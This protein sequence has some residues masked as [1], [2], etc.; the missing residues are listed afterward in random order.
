MSDLKKNFGYNLLLTTGNYLI[1]LI[2]YPYISRVLGV[3]K[4]GICGFVDGLINYFV[5]FAA[6]GVFGLG[7]REIARCRDN[8]IQRSIVF[9]S[10]FAINAVCTFFSV[11]VLVLCTF[12]VE[13]FIPYKDFLLIGILKLIFSL[14]LIEW[15]F[16]GLQNFRYIT[17]RTLVIRLLYLISVFL[18]VKRESDILV[19]YF[20]TVMV[21][22]VNSIFNWSFSRKYRKLSIRFIKVKLFISSVVAFGCYRI[23][24]SMYTTFNA[25][26]LGFV[27][28]MEEVGFF[29]TANKL[30]GIIMSFFTAFTVVMVPKV[31]EMLKC[32]LY[33]SL[34]IT[35]NKIFS[36]LE[37]LSFPL[38]FYCLF[39]ASSIINVISGPGYEG[40]ILPFRIIV[41]LFFI[42]GME[43]IVITQFLLSAKS[44]KAIFIISSVG[45]VAGIFLN[46]IL[47][48]IFGSVGS[49]ISWGGAEFLV[50]CVGIKYLDILM[51]LKINF[52]EFW[53][54]LMT[55][56]LY[57]FPLVLLRFFKQSDF[58]CLISNGIVLV[59]LFLLI[60]LKIKRNEVLFNFVNK[61]YKK[62]S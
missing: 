5:L 59:F 18:F 56:L 30:F 15:F 52:K 46:V 1:P 47:T 3:E 55:S 8:F 25:V 31:S 49:A 37:I 35:A 34:Q 12:F 41:V 42:V 24:T 21:I 16:Q 7:V 53:H 44:N 17:I 9:S 10:L 32:G 2:L 27:A 45:A 22:V 6:L 23:L 39:C 51:H 26:F 28:G 33:E 4:I 13:Y 62:R 48:P 61:F 60:N 57:L 58:C 29:S 40:A 20:L 43:Q 36:V 19:Y 38:I 50:L 14:F 11:I 54:N